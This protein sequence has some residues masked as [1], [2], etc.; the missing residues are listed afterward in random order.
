MN[1][2]HGH[3]TTDSGRIKHAVNVTYNLLINQKVFSLNNDYQ[4]KQ[5]ETVLTT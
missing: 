3:R 4:N 1:P 5:S 2:W